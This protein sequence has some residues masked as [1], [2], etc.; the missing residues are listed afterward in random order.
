[1]GWC[2]LAAHPPTVV[3]QLMATAPCQVLAWDTAKLRGPDKGTWYHLYVI[4]DIYSR[5]IRGFTVERAESADRAE[6]LIR[7]TIERDGI[8][9]QTVHVDRGTAMTSKKVSRLLIDLGVTRDHSRPKVSD[10]NPY[11]EA[12]FKAIKYRGEYP[13]SFDSLAHAREWCDGFVSYDNHEH[14]HCGIGPHPGFGAPRH[15]RPGA[16]ATRRHPHGGLPPPP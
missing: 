2:R 4:I 8:V 14:R 1:V 7:E 11:S 10:D 9:P 3:S 6:E 16:R 5:Y 12:N 13:D 15:R